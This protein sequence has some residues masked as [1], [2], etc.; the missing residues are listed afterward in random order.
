M[1]GT[2]TS[3]VTRDPVAALTFDD[4]PHPEYTPVLL[5]TLEPHQARA[6]FLMVGKAAQR[7]PQLMQ[8]VAQA[9]HAVADHSWDHAFL[10]SLPRH[11]RQKQFRACEH[12][13]AP[14]GQRLFR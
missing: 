10:P 1:Q 6:T 4:G 8:Q 11:E 3:V 12:V 5:K 13:L 14:Y 9:G 2:I 7:H